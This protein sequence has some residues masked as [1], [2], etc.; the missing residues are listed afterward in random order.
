MLDEKQRAAIK[1]REAI[2]SI[3]KAMRL[4]IGSFVGNATT[5]FNGFAS[6]G[7]AARKICIDKV[8]RYAEENLK[9]FECMAFVLAQSDYTSMLNNLSA[10]L[11]RSLEDAS[12]AKS[13][14]EALS[15]VDSGLTSSISF[16]EK[17]NKEQIFR[18]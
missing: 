12:K 7:A 18:K 16:M 1:N 6:E 5:I 3:R 10:I 4:E 17:S 15:A 2:E 9:M 13:L 8:S 14:R 11:R